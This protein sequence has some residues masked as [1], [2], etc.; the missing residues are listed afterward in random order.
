MADLDLKSIIAK[1]ITGLRKSMNWTQ[2]ELAQKLNYTDKAISKWERAE[3]TPDVTVLKSM[4]DLFQVPVNYLFEDGHPKERIHLSTII[5]QLKKRSHIIIA[6]VSAAG[7]FFIATLL[8]VI[9]GLFSV[10]VCQP[11][12]MLYVYAIPL[13][14]IVLLVFNS[15]WGK[16]KVNLIIISALI[17]TILLSI[18]LSYQA[19]N[20]WLVFIIGIPAQIIVLLLAPIKTIKLSMFVKPKAK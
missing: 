13:S 19:P 7:I 10:T 4:A 9:S 12:W 8:Y 18:Y 5:R 3:S 15:I 17:W 14:M 11:S 16:K 2:A 6:L 20:T 1:N